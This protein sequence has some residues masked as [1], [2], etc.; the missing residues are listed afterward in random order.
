[1][2]VVMAEKQERELDWHRMDLAKQWWW[3]LCQEQTST[4]DACLALAMYRVLA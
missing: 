1:M 2:V 3:S 4:L